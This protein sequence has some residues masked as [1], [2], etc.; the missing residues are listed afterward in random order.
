MAKIK[1]SEV[2]TD[3]EKEAADKL[4]AEKEAA[5]KLLADKALAEKASAAVTI[6]EGFVLMQAPEWSNGITVEGEE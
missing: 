5:D 6:P 2:E 3:A 1:S 4:L